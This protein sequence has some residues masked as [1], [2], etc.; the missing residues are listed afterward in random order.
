MH[1]HVL[2]D[3]GICGC[4]HPWDFA[5]DCRQDNARY[6]GYDDYAQRNGVSEDDVIVRSWEDRCNADVI[7][8]P[9]TTARLSE[10]L[11]GGDDETL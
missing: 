7:E 6:N 2:Y 9:L 3:C 5:G 10:L 1:Q 11:R 4:L 8:Y